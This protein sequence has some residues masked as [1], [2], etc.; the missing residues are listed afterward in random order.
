MASG[1]IRSENITGDFQSLKIKEV[2]SVGDRLGSEIVS[3]LESRNLD[4]QSG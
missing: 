1:T 4:T 3:L 2:S